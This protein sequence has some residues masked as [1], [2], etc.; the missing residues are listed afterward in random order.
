[1]YIDLLTQWVQEVFD[2]PDATLYDLLL[3]HPKMRNAFLASPFSGQENQVGEFFNAFT[4]G[5]TISSPSYGRL[6]FYFNDSIGVD[7]RTIPECGASPAH[8]YRRNIGSLSSHV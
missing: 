2:D 1:V 4:V 5:H 7:L 6:R 8:I 3:L